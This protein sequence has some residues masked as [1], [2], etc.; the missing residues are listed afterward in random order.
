MTIKLTWDAAGKTLCCLG[1][2]LLGSAAMFQYLG[3][4]P[5]TALCTLGACSSAILGLLCFVEITQPE[6]E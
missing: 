1:A 2:F 5:A 6:D 3:D 4:L